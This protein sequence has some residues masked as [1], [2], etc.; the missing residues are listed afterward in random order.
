M[1][2][3]ID[4]AKASLQVCVLTSP[5]QQ[6]SFDNTRSGWK[7]LAKYLKQW[8]AVWVAMEATGRYGD[9]VSKHLYAAGYRLSVVNP[10]RIKAYA[11]SQ[12]KRQKT[13]VI[14]AH[15]IADFC[16]TQEPDLWQPLSAEGEELREI[17]R[18]LDDLKD[19]RQREKNRLEAKP[20]SKAV[21]KQIEQLIALLDKQIKQTQKDIEHLVKQHPHLQSQSN[22]ISSIPGVGLLTAARVMAELGDLSQYDDVRQ[23]VALTG[24]DPTRKQSG[25]SLNRSGGI[26]RMGHSALR[27]A[28]FMPALAAMRYNPILKAFAERLKA[29]G[30]LPKQVVIAVMRKLLHLAYGVIKSG[31]PFDPNFGKVKLS[32]P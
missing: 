30:L 19:A 22:L 3:G 24:L 31:I 25:S 14:D 9:G 29:Q 15:L 2:V 10:A 17:T 13:D 27:A 20:K 12:M 7:A 6:V 5:V 11:Q 28:L 21:V 8:D 23:I 26:A 32:T 1:Y 4:V 18:H 16:R